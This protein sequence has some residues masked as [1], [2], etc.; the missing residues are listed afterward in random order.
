MSNWPQVS[1]DMCKSPDMCFV[2]GKGNPIGLKLKFRWENN[3]ATAEFTPNELF[4]GWNGF[5]HGG[6]MACLLDEA[7]TYAAYYAGINCVTARMEVRLRQLLPVG[8]PLV[9]SGTISKR[10]RKLVETTATLTLRDGTRVADGSATMFVVDG[11]PK[12]SNEK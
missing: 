10:T 1:A 3:V 9:I 8:E 5:V 11:P 2:C 4:Q 7:L 6:I 12:E